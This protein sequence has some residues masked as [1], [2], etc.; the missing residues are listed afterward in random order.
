MKDH[1]IAKLVNELTETANKF[2]GCQ[3]MRTV[4]HDV[5]IKYIVPEW[6]LKQAPPQCEVRDE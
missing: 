1:E 2:A 4:L 3:C 5:V 6:K